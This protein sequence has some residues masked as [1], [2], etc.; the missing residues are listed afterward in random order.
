MVGVSRNKRK[1]YAKEAANV[2]SNPLPGKLRGVLLP[3]AAPAA[4][5]DRTTQVSSTT[6]N[7]N[8]E[9][10]QHIRTALSQLKRLRGS[11]G[12]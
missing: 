11:C 1:N 5:N 10:V 7:I 3:A 12:S 2:I 6:F 8:P 4:E 9:S